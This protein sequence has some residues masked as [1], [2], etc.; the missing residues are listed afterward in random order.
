M[1]LRN[2]WVCTQLAALVALPLNEHDAKYVPII[3]L[4][5]SFFLEILDLVLIEETG[6]ICTPK[7]R[8]KLEYVKTEKG[9]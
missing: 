5:N 6:C 7:L 4:S 3:V 9:T 2:D 1:F 8:V